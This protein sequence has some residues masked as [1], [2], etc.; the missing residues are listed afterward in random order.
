VDIKKYA[1]TR[2]MDTRTD[3]DTGIRQIFIQWVGYA[4][5]T[6]RTLPTPL[7]SLNNTIQNVIALYKRGP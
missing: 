4:R 5:A 7:T 1:G 2:I 6:T 3:M